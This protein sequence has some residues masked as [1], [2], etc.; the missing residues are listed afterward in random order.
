MNIKP[1]ES[2]ISVLSRYPPSSTLADKNGRYW[3]R[4]SRMTITRHRFISYIGDDQD[5]Y[6]EQK[7]LLNVANTDQSEVVQTSH[8]PGLS[9]V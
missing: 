2:L 6:Y 1:S 4:Q 7:F 9:T 8:P 3:V 5:K